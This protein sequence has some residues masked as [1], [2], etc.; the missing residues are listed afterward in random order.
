[1]CVEGLH[2]AG[3]LD[4]EEAAA[5]CGGGAVAIVD[6][7]GED[8]GGEAGAC[9]V[10]VEAAGESGGE[11]G[12]PGEGYVEEVSVSLVEAAFGGVANEVGHA[13]GSSYD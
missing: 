8:V 9:G 10:E 12:A 1:M 3:V 11:S 2:V 13:V 4:G 7:V 6:D 5:R